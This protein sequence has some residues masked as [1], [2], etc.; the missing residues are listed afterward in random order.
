VILFTHTGG[1]LASL[2]PSWKIIKSEAQPSP[3]I[4]GNLADMTKLRDLRAADKDMSANAFLVKKLAGV[5]GLQG[6]VLSVPFPS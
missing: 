2:A 4:A 3:Y 5:F 1:S 6:F